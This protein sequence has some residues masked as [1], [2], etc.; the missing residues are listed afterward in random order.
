MKVYINRFFQSRLAADLGFGTE[1]ANFRYIASK[2]AFL[3]K[4]DEHV[5]VEN[6]FIDGIRVRVYTPRNTDSKSLPA[7]IYYHGGGFFMGFVGK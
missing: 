1:P 6:V 4:H 2:G 7:I 3:L 5:N